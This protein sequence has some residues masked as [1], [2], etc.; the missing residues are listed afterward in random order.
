MSGEPAIH[1][2]LPVL[3]DGSVR[4]QRFAKQRGEGKNVLGED[5]SAVDR[6]D[7]AFLHQVGTSLR[8]QIGHL[9]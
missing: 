2:F 5:A 3:S 4:G 9:P 1:T 8:Q 6:L 7:I